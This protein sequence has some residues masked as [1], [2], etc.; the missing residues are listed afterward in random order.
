MLGDDPKLAPDDG[1]VISEVGPWAERKYRLLATYAGMFATATKNRWPKRVYIDLF[2][3]CG[4]ALIRGTSRIVQA[5]PL[6]ALS[7]V[8]PFSLHVF[9]EGES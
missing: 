9:C 3:G 5:S 7:V 2:S 1:L 6:L 4:K 8:D